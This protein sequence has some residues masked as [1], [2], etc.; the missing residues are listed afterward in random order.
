MTQPATRAQKIQ[1]LPCAPWRCNEIAG[2]LH[3]KVHIIAQQPRV[4]QLPHVLALVVSCRLMQGSGMAAGL[5]TGRART[6]ATDS[7]CSRPPLQELGAHPRRK[8]ARKRG[9]QGKAKQGSSGRRWRPASPVIAFSLVYFLR[10][11]PSSLS[12]RSF[13]CS[14]VEQPRMSW[15]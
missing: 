7:N 8:L 10:I 5:D 12:T 6:A 1:L 4:H 2:I 15:M 11:L 14:F 3:A 9:Q 13:S